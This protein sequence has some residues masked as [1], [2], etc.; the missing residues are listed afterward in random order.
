MLGHH[1]LQESEAEP[2]GLAGGGLLRIAAAEGPLKRRK[3]IGRPLGHKVKEL[4]CRRTDTGVGVL[5]LGDEEAAGLGGEGPVPA[6]RSNQGTEDTTRGEEY[7]SDAVLEA[8][9]GRTCQRRIRADVAGRHLRLDPRQGR[10]AE[11]VVGRHGGITDKWL[12]AGIAYGCGVASAP[13]VRRL[14]IR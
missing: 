3:G 8:F 12:A 2:N 9:Q 13:L 14:G 6:A 1:L 4:D 7:G 11:P 5:R 10:L